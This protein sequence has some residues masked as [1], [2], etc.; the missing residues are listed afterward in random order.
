M[1][2]A[3]EDFC[4]EEQSLADNFLQKQQKQQKTGT[5]VSVERTGDP[6]RAGQAARVG[7]PTPRL[8]DMANVPKR[9]GWV[10]LILWRNV[11]D[12]RLRRRC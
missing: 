3:I 8:S 2:L 1:V 4:G 7:K 10:I 12:D 6:A 5:F 11:R 9:S